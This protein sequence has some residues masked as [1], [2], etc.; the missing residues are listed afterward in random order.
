MLTEG[1]LK[2]VVRSPLWMVYRVAGRGVKSGEGP[3]LPDLAGCGLD[4]NR[5]PNAIRRFQSYYY[6]TGLRT[7]SVS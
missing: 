2:L 6:L 3:S 4:P 7:S 1:H 5:W